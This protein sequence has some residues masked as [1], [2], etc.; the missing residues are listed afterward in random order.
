[1]VI[2]PADIPSTH[3]DE[4]YKTYMRDARGIGHA[5]SAGQL[6]S[7]L[8]ECAWAAKRT[9]P[10]LALYYSEQIRKGKNGKAAIVKVARKLLSRIRYVWLS[11]EPYQTA[12][13]K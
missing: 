11:G 5:L 1:M 3:K 2:N 4:V 9:D 12:V 7:D 10:A 8:V 6:R 13:V